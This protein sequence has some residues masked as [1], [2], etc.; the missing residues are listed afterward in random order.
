MKGPALTWYNGLKTNALGNN[1]GLY[2]PLLDSHINLIYIYQTTS[3]RNTSE[4]KM[5]L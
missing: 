1:L 4:T 3:E 5:E 2:I